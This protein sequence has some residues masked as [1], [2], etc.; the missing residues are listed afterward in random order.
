MRRR[1]RLLPLRDELPQFVELPLPLVEL[2]VARVQ[3]MLFRFEARHG[4]RIAR[5]DVAEHRDR[6]ER[7]A[8]LVDGQ[9]HP[10][11]TETA[12]AIE[13]GEP[14]AEV[15]LLPLHARRDDGDLRLDVVPLDLE[16]R[17]GVDCELQLARPDAELEID[18]F[19]LVLRRFRLRANVFEPLAELVDLGVDAVEV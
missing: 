3:L 13:R 8:M 10:H 4:A 6:A 5:D 1:D 2:G 12:E 17:L 15:L 19:E 16:L 7:I 11:V 18:G 9:K 14:L